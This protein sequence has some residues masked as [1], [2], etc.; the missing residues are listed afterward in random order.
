MERGYSLGRKPR[1]VY[2]T[3]GVR[4]GVFRKFMEF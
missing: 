3:D 1:V 2:G 4:I